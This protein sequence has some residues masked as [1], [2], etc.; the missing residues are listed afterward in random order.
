MKNQ[1]YSVFLTLTMRGLISV[2][3]LLMAFTAFGQP[4]LPTAAPPFSDNFNRASLSPGGSPSM[5]YTV[6]STA[7]PAGTAV[8]TAS[9]YAT[10]AANTA[11]G[12][13]Y[14][15]GPLATFASPYNVTLSANAAMTS[16]SFNIRNDKST[17]LTGLS[18]GSTAVAVVLVADNATLTGATTRGYAVTLSGGTTGNKVD[19]GYFTNG[20]GSATNFTSFITTTG[21]ITD[22]VAAT[23]ISVKVTYTPSTNT[24]A[25]FV[26]DDGATPSTNPS[27]VSTQAGVNTVNNSLTSVAMNSFGFFF[28]HTNSTNT[29]VFDNFTVNQAGSVGIIPTPKYYYKGTGDLAVTSSWGVNADGSGSNPPNFTTAAAEFNI[30][31]TTAVSTQTPWTVSGTGSK[32]TVG[33]STVPSVILTIES[34]NEING[35]IDIPKTNSSST[36]SNA[37]ILKSGFMPKFGALDSTS[38]VIFQGTQSLPSTDTTSFGKVIIKLGGVVSFTG[39]QTVKSSLAVEKGAEL[40]LG[41]ASEDRVSIGANASVDIK[42]MVK[43][44]KEEGFVSTNVTTPSSTSASLQFKDAAAKMILD[45]E[46]A[47]FFNRN[48]PNSTQKVSRLPAGVDYHWIELKGSAKALEHRIAVAKTMTVDTAV[49]LTATDTAIIELRKDASVAIKGKVKV[50]NESGLISQNVSTPSS[51]LG[52]L[53]FEDAEPKLTLDTSS[54]IEYNRSVAGSTQIIS[55]LPTGVSYAKV[56][57]TDGGV[58]CPKTTQ[59]PITVTNTL[60][61]DLSASK[62][63]AGG[64]LNIQGSMILNPQTQLDLNGNNLNLQPGS[65]IKGSGTIKGNVQNPVGCKVSPGASPGTT[66]INGNF[67]NQGDWDIELSGATA[68]TEYDHVLVTGT[69]TLTGGTVNVT[70]INGYNPPAS[71]SFVILDAASLTGT[72]TTFN[73][74]VLSGGKTWA[75]PVY[76]NA[77]GTLTLTVN[78]VLD[79]ELLDF[80]VKSKQK[81]ALLTW[82]TTSEKDNAFFNIEQSTNGTDFQTIGQVKGH[83]TTSSENKYAFTDA[84]PSVGINYYRLKQVDLNGKATYSA[85]QTVLMGKTGLVVK[86]TLVRDA[87]DIVTTDE[88]STPLSIF[89]MTGQE[90]LNIKVQGS[91]RLNIST[92]PAGLYIIQTGTGDVARFV[93]SL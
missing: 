54:K 60:N 87:L 86:T 15:T 18:D 55:E 28:N 9:T 51:T 41:A 27:T 53:Q 39:K 26:R 61:V 93:K 7:S 25:L 49:V 50:A 22:M 12:R 6:A 19:L 62:L 21:T 43:V 17:P 59:G 77:D 74:P 58:N 3:M 56:E 52:L 44:S 37:L 89:S 34:V 23:N 63:T 1:F 69:A 20:L 76:N 79:V 8:I 84:T 85:V 83:G 5:T 10:I 35:T 48:Q 4:G 45:K 2:V 81:S 11:A 32:I 66:N 75:T 24:W 90:V 80:Q 92:L 38:E 82:T 67:T 40:S 33:G 88:S 70:L 91:Q 13:T 47:I 72:F 46:S 64:S 73:L 71:A 78:A 14:F 29:T 30:R 36:T 57:I 65:T 31:N 68:G 16:W 42:G